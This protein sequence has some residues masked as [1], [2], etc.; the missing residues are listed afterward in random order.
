MP[1]IAR[2]RARRPPAPAARQRPTPG[3]SLVVELSRR[4]RRMGGYTGA[5]TLTTVNAKDVYEGLALL[6]QHIPSFGIRLKS[7]VIADDGVVT[8][9]TDGPISDDQLEHVGLKE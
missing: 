7:I 5:L 3:R 4:G 8:V 9:I 2:I 6:L 1:S